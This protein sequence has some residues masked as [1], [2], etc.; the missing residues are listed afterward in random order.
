MTIG[1]MPKRC[2]AALSEMLKMGMKR[3]FMEKDIDE[4]IESYYDNVMT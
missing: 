4:M 1:N 2:L 3:N